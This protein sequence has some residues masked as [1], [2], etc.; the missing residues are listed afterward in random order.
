MLANIAISEIWKTN[1]LEPDD[2]PQRGLSELWLQASQLLFSFFF[3]FR[4]GGGH[5]AKL[6]KIQ[7]KSDYSFFLLIRNRQIRL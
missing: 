7:I 3:F 1:S 5:F 2:C 6:E 4:G